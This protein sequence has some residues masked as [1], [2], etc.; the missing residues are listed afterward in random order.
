MMPSTVG[1]V[2]TAMRMSRRRLASIFSSLG[3][4]ESGMLGLVE[5]SAI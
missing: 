1:G 4:S 5:W 2:Y 3:S